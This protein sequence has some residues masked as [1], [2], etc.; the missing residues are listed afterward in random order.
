MALILLTDPDPEEA[1]VRLMKRSAYLLV[2]MSILFIK[3]Y[4]ELGRGFDEWTGAAM[5]YGIYGDK[6]G[7]GWTC[8][9]LGFFFFWHLLQ[10]LKT[11]KGKARRN[12][13]RLTVGFLIMISWLLAK[14]S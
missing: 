4:P 9:I 3:Y 11:E 1:I 14:A 13:L 5:N 6:N 8:M 12:E 10:T 2:P 7:L